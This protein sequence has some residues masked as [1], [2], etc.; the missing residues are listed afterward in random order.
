[1]RSKRYHPSALQLANSL[2]SLNNSRIKDVSPLGSGSVRGFEFPAYQL[3]PAR[4]YGF[5]DDFD[6]VPGDFGRGM[7]EQV[8]TFLYDRSWS[9][10]A[11]LNTSQNMLH[12]LSNDNT[13]RNNAFMMDQRIPQGAIITDVV[14]E[15]LET[16]SGNSISNFK[17]GFFGDD[18]ALLTSDNATTLS[19]GTIYRNQGA[20]MSSSNDTIKIGTTTNSATLLKIEGDQ[21][22]TAGK[23]AC[24]IKYL[25]SLT[26]NS[27]YVDQDNWFIAP[28]IGNLNKDNSDERKIHAAWNNNIVG[29][30][31]DTGASFVGG[32]LELKPPSLGVDYAVNVAALGKRFE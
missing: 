28:S 13:E 30:E 17:I 1:M 5:H 14:V 29:I 3:M 31:F 6:Y 11:G 24:Y 8:S 25:T 32:C 16:I 23:V 7:Q 20:L 15:V 10:A 22:N 12:P 26:S 18:D 4:Y 2:K 19:A 21:A 9:N 27:M